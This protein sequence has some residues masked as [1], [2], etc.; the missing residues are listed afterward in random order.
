MPPFALSSLDKI[1]KWEKKLTPSCF[2]FPSRPLPK[3]T[4][5]FQ[6]SVRDAFAG[7]TVFITGGTGYVGSVLI[8][9]LLRCVPELAAIQM[10][11]RPKYGV[12]PADRIDKL[13]EKPLFDALRCEPLQPPGVD[14][15]LAP[16]SAVARSPLLP[17]LRAKLH[18]V[19]G[20]VV[21]PRCGLSEADYELVTR[22]ATY[23]IH[24]AASISFTDPVQA[25]AQQNYVATRNVLELVEAC[26][27]ASALAG[28]GAGAP[29][30]VG[31]AGAPSASPRAPESPAGVGSGSAALRWAAARGGNSNGFA[32]VDSASL[33]DD[34]NAPAGGGPFRGMVHV[35]T[36]Y[37]NAHLPIG[38]H[39]DERIYYLRD[40]LSSGSSGS[41]T[42]S[43]SSSVTTASSSSSSRR[44]DHAG[45]I[46]KILA[47]PS[48]SAADAIATPILRAFRFPNSY[49]FT[50]HLAEEAVADAHAAGK[51]RAVVVR[52]SIIGSIAEAPAPGYFGNAAGLTQVRF[53]CFFC[54]GVVYFFFSRFAFSFSSRR[55]FSRAL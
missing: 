30:A 40:V 6:P 16:R 45:T 44:L 46:A 29:K 15:V 37:V 2:P 23:V 7:A 53:F 32:T 19:P 14:G 27:S 38:S 55:A 26:H 17:H 28:A 49:T 11:V 41:S 8:E 48:A 9:Q 54:F 22:R 47:A 25:L 24:C 34:V 39:V 13:L 50:K 18:A 4:P 52:P 20:D 43:T 5:T 33:D 31:V 42:S 12:D 51:L 35:S 1:K 36:C 3:P 21:R 10:L